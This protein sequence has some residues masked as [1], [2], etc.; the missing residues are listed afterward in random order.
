MYDMD[1]V[2]H[3]IAVRKKGLIVRRWHPEIPRHV[4]DER[5]QAGV[6]LPLYDG[7]YRHAAVPMTHDMRLLSAV[8]AAGDD[9]RLFGRAAA[10]LHG[11]PGARR[12]RPEIA[13]PHTDL[14][15]LP[16][17]DRHRVLRFRPFEVTTVRGIPVTSKGR[18]A[19]DYCGLVPFHIAHEVIAAAVITKVLRPEDVVSTIERS[20]GRGVRGT[21]NLRAIGLTLDELLGLESVLEQHGDRELAMANVPPWVRQHEIVCNDGRRVRCDMAWPELRLALDWDGK[22]WHATPARKKHT[23]ERH[24]SIVA[25]SWGHLTYGWADVHLT[26]REMR[27]EVESEVWSR[28]R[29]AA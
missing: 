13:S 12:L 5:V 3:Q 6:L 17:V 2:L 19:L 27:A 16:G 4:F 1:R 10:A 24:D 22:R 18:T 28:L 20:G 15:V 29:R 21:A 7:V 14:P 26:P 23:R 8:L 25:S 9:A 11:F